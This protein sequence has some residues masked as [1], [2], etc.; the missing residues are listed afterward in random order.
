MAR[1]YVD[2]GIATV[3]LARKPTR[4]LELREVMLKGVE[5]GLALREQVLVPHLLS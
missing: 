3:E 5:V 1:R 4:E 2:D